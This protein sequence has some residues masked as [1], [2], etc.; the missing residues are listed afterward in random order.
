MSTTTMTASMRNHRGGK[1]TTTGII[2]NL[3]ELGRIVIPIEIRKRFGLTERDPL[4]IS[5]KDQTILLSRPRTSCVF[6]GTTRSVEEH[7]GRGV[8]QTCLSELAELRA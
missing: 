6:C 3:D 7:R 5:V 4:E 1:T 2:R 8:C